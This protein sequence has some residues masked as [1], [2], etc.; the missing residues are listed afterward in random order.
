MARPLMINGKLPMKIFVDNGYRYAVTRTSVRKPDG[1]YN[2]PQKI[3]GTVD[4]DLNFYPNARYLALSDTEKE[5]MLIPAEW[6]L[7]HTTLQEA[8]STMGNGRAPRFDESSS[9]LYGHTWFLDMLAD[10]SGLRDD[11]IHIFEDKDMADNVLS[12]AFFTL[13]GSSSFSHLSSEQRTTWFPA[14]SPIEAWDATR[15]TASITETHKQALFRCRKARTSKTSWLGI[16]STSFTHYG[17][18][19]SDSKRGKN[20]EHDMADQINVMVL[21]DITDGSPV[22]YRK[23]PG[24]MPDTRSMRVTLDEFKTNGFGN[25]NLV[26]DRGYV[27]EEV[28]TMLVKGKHPFVMM[29]KTG[30]AQIAK[31]I[32]ETNYEE[33]VD[34]Q[35]WIDKH[36]IFGKVLDYKFKV[37]VK[38]EERNV[39]TMKICLFFDPEHQGENRKEIHKI[40]SE[41]ALQL[42]N[43]KEDKETV[44]ADTMSK[45]SRY[46]DIVLTKD[47]KIKHYSINDKKMRTDAN[48]TGYFAVLTNC[49]SPSRHDL[50][51]ILDIYG[52][53]D[54][55]EKSFM[56]VKS[57]QDGRRLR[58][59]K[60]ENSNGRL[61]IQ[62]VALVL[63]CIIYRK[64]FASKELQ[65]LFPTRQH[66]LEELRS[67]RLIRHP[68]KAKIITEIVG[69]QVDVFKEFK[70]HV[71]EKL[72]PK[73][74]RKE[75]AEALVWKP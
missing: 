22:Y 15:L 6:K 67:I 11:L 60:E 12:M 20:K 61:F 54:E 17:K 68:R 28:V 13:L 1:K 45:Y 5:S 69:R 40:V 30:D 50:S 53:R 57:E 8:N 25:V 24:N 75:F 9:L 3:W 44:D 70:L 10:S 39:D 33:M 52:M 55:Q 71:P 36:G 65:K 14:D 31:A 7:Q 42:G 41:M 59:S 32:R 63:N 56:F 51:E 46:F 19:L 74:R 4:E 72:L 49:M 48:K 2:H 62:F 47:R 35:H 43:M 64:F 29:A 27:S 58:T 18:M 26:L 38:G 37:T 34:H 21:Y 16:D 73:D 66:M 23:M